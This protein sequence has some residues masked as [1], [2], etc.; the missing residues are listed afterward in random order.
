MYLAHMKT[1]LEENFTNNGNYYT[2]GQSLQNTADASV[3]ADLNKFFTYT[4]FTT[5]L[6]SDVTSGGG[7]GSTT[8]PGITNLM[9][10]RYNYL[11]SQSDFTAT[12]PSISNISVSNSTIDIGNTVTIT[13]TV[14]DEQNV[15]LNYRSQDYAPFT[16]VEMFDDGNHND[17]ASNDNVFGADITINAITTHY[18][19]YAEN[20]NI[21]K[22][23][24]ARAQ[25]EFYTLNATGGIT[26]GDIVINEFMASN[27]TT[28]V[29]QDGEY[30]DWIELYN[31]SESAIDISGYNLSD[32]IDDLTLFTFPSGTIFQPN[33]Y[34]IVWADKDLSQSDYHADFKLSTSGET[35]YL[36]DASQ[37]LLDSVA[38]PSLN[39]DEAFGRYP[40]GTGSFQTLPATF[41]AENNTGQTTSINELVNN[42][43]FNIYPNPAQDYFTIEVSNNLVE[44]N[45]L[46]IYNANGQQVYSETI[47]EKMVIRTDQFNNGLYFIIIG[48][49]SKKL[50]INR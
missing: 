41:E 22:F 40:N 2:M 25:H 35:L 24:P 45:N 10:S 19:I 9:N 1:I 29:D 30:E 11:M 20:S 50:I 17:G 42:S 47:Q 6:T 5:N 36:T 27:D 12:Q 38:F 8:V 13:A 14:N 28:V 7:P 16:K 43:I 3:Q 48:N 32:D 34:I 44:N 15:Y 18:Y 23:S 37:T 26:P 39:T 46:I 31:N 21:G 33:T 49:N 4:Q